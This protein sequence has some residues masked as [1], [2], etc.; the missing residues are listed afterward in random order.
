MRLPVW[1]RWAGSLTVM[2]VLAVY[3]V[4]LGSPPLYAQPGENN[5][6]YI[7]L[8]PGP[9]IDEDGQT[10]N[11]V[12]PEPTLE[13]TPEPTEELTPDPESTPD[14]EFT[15]EPDGS[16]SELSEAAVIF[17]A[18]FETGNLNQWLNGGQI[19]ISGA[20]KA[21]ANTSI[22][23]KGRYAAA[24]T[25]YDA[26]GT[27]NPQPGVRLAWNAAGR[28]LPSEAKNLPD[29]AYYSAHY[30]FPQQVATEW[31]NIMQWKQ[32]LKTP[33][34]GQTRIPVYFVSVIGKNNQMYLALRSK[35]SSQGQYTEPGTTAA[36]WSKPIPIKSWVRLECLYRWSKQANGR[37]ACWQ[38]GTLIWDVKNIITE[39]EIPY[40]SYPRQW[41][42]NNYAGKTS[43]TNPLLYID[44]AAILTQRLGTR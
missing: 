11:E 30:Y 16:E 32:A 3:L 44:E 25:I 28:V 14:P 34:G 9:Y 27:T 7:P 6:L 36:Y 12:T 10:P 37:I 42:I 24:L 5:Q 17:S 23:Y 31:W 19:S 26:N 21:S 38:N 29:E 15:P 18:D 43:P 1:L 8:V 2:A 20:T 4:S 22:V 39:F 13:V 40:K 33:D 41:T 35:V